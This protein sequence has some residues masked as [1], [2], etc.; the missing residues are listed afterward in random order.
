MS[1]QPN[2][3]G[4]YRALALQ[5]RCDAVNSISD[6]AACRAQ[7]M[8]SIARIDRQIAASKMFSGDDLKLVVLPEYFLTSFPTGP[9]LPTWAARACLLQD[10]PE[11]KA[12]G[13]VA[14]KNGVYLS[15][16]AYEIDPK[17]SDLSFQVSF[18]INDQGELILRYRRLIS[19]Y[20]ATPHDVWDKFVDVYGAEAAFPVADTPLGNLACIASEEIL[21]PEVARSLALRGAEIFL[22]SSSETGSPQATKKGIAK[23]A[24][25]VE[26]LAYVVS[27]NSAGIAG[28]DI[29]MASTDSGSMVIDY[30]GR[31]LAEAGYG[32]SMVALTQIDPA[33]IRHVR[34]R[35]GMDNY[36]ARLR[37]E[38]FATTY[39]MSVYPP[40]V[41]ANEKP[42]R[43][44]FRAAI[45]R[46]IAAIQNKA[47]PK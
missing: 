39:Q 28:I 18:I 22:H 35:V 1:S 33:T 2:L 32:E 26:N 27:A 11:Y 13:E 34:G 8:R 15:G 9:D 17:F 41:L 47:T 29:P 37:L 6:V 19:M 46:G 43:A 40:N 12:L 4:P 30:E 45:E 42:S 24:R 3:F 21:F 7:M 10:G 38:P 31:I 20:T 23:R 14:K 5:I 16:N 44:G 36:L 25:A